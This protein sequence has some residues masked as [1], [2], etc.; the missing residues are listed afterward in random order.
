[1]KTRRHIHPSDPYRVLR[2]PDGCK[3]TF[4][5]NEVFPDDP[6]QGTPVMLTLKSGDTAT[7]NCA[8]NEGEAEGEPLTP[9]QIDWLNELAFDVEEWES[10]QFNEARK[11][12]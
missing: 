3:I 5:A 10:W 9:A 8:L 11:R 7:F 1:M 4:N 6:G 2:G 12:L